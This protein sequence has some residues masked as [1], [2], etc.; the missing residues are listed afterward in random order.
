MWTASSMKYSVEDE[1]S[2]VTFSI[3]QS[4]LHLCPKCRALLRTKMFK[5]GDCEQVGVKEIF[6]VEVIYL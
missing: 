3:S 5:I 2:V 1:N 4:C 6:K